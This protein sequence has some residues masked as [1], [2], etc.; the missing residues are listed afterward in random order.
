MLHGVQTVILDE[1]HAIVAMKAR[2]RFRAAVAARRTR[3]MWGYSI[4][5]R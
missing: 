1:I 4:L 2:V 5:G 3:A